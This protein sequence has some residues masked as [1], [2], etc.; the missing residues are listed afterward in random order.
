MIWYIIITGVF[1]IALSIMLRRHA[2]TLENLSRHF[3]PTSNR[4]ILGRI[5]NEIEGYRRVSKGL[6]WVTSVLWVGYI[7]SIVRYFII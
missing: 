6:L 7:F 2:D 4:P 1:A 5:E 3:S